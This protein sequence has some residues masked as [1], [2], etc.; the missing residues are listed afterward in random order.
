VNHNQLKLLKDIKYYLN[1][2]HSELESVEQIW[3]TRSLS[4]EQL[5]KL[6]QIQVYLEDLYND[7]EE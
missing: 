2:A 4:E 5:E 7:I 6:L 3:E 1:R